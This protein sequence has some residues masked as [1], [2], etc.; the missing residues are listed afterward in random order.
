MPTNKDFYTV[1]TELVKIQSEMIEPVAG[2]LIGRWFNRCQMALEVKNTIDKK[3]KDENR[4]HTF[5]EHLDCEMFWKECSNMWWGVRALNKM[6]I[7]CKDATHFNIAISN[8]MSKIADYIE[9]KLG[10]N[11]ILEKSHKGFGF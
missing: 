4:E 3:V 2:Q 8:E 9:D 6:G 5:H 10:F 11:P 1:D 7:A